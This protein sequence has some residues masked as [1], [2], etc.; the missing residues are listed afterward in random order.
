MFEHSYRHQFIE[1]SG[2]LPVV[3]KL[4]KDSFPQAQF[5]YFAAHMV[6]LVG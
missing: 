3:K 2:E 1:F 4:R 6:V 5:F